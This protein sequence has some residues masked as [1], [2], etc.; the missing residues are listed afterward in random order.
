MI[1]ASITMAMPM[2]M[3]ISLIMTVRATPKP[4]K[5]VAMMSAAPVMRRPVAAS[6]ATTARSLSR[7]RSNS[8]CVRLSSSTS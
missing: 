3:P 7:V 8:S 5:T 1:V 6:E 2:P 4:K